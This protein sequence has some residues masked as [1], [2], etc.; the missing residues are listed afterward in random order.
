MTESNGKKKGSALGTFCGMIG[1]LVILL[2]LAV[3]VL[4]FAPHYL[5]FELYNVLTGSME[6]EI[7][8]GSL[9][10]VQK[11]EADA[12]SEGD[13]IAFHRPRDGSVVTHRLQAIDT[14]RKELI[15]KG[16]ANDQEDL[17]PIPF[18][19][20][21]GKVRWH[22]AGVG[23]FAEWLFSMTGKICLFAILV[24]GVILTHVAD[25]LKKG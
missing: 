25:S 21:I 16:D 12:L 6:P 24:A 23:S 9:V 10:V 3:A 14:E 22:F 17:Q 18:L 2:V 8:A 7:P 1:T 19:N 4:A 5:G 15:T 11:V 13:V 20:L